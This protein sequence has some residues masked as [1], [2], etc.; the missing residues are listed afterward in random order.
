MKLPGP[1]MPIAYSP[2]TL[3]YSAGDNITLRRQGG[4]KKSKMAEAGESMFDLDGDGS[5]LIDSIL[6][7]DESK[8]VFCMLAMADELGHKSPLPGFHTSS[9][10][11]GASAHTRPRPLSLSP[12]PPGRNSE[13]DARDWTPGHDE[14]HAALS[15]QTPQL[16]EIEL[17]RRNSY[18]AKVSLLNPFGIEI[19]P[20]GK[21]EP[22]DPNTTAVIDPSAAD[23][24]TQSPPG[25]PVVVTPAVVSGDLY[26]VDGEPAWEGPLVTEGDGEDGVV[27]DGEATL[28]GDDIPTDTTRNQYPDPEAVATKMKL[29]D[30]MLN[31]LMN[32]SADVNI[33]VKEMEKSLE[34]SYKEIKD[35]KKENVALKLRL[36]NLELEDRRTQFHAKATDDKL[37]RL[38]T[39]TKKKNLILE[40]IPEQDGRREVLEKT[41][42]DVFDQLDV[43]KGV[44]FEACYRI[45]P[46]NKAKSRPILISFEK[47]VD[48]ELIYSRRMDL[49]RTR[50]YQ[51]VWVNEDLGAAS[52]RK[53]G[54]I[55]LSAKEAQA[56]GIDCRSGKYSLHIDNTRYDDDNLTELPPRLQPSNLKQVKIDDKTLVYQSEHAPFSNFYPC[57]LQV[58][59]HKF[60]CLEQ[61]F[62][63]MRAKTL[64]KHLIATKIYLSRDVRFIKQ[65]GNE[66]GTAEEWEARKFEVMYGL[67]KKKFEQHPTLRALLLAT[68][69]FELVEATPDRTWDCG[70]TLSSNVLR[71][72]EW[73]G[74]NKHGETLMTVRDELLAR[75]RV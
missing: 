41:I 26:G 12:I 51:H 52:K 53:R 56:Q 58:G 70:A 31:Q 55:R 4:L 63:F 69:G 46:Y 29:V 45:G 25:A 30:D 48:R 19:S 8:D 71:R 75:V 13:Q 3:D 7:Q 11:G 64:G 18:N 27:K 9:Q 24:L 20:H 23:P 16:G 68:A 39:A 6:S 43:R 28:L 2:A 73:P 36:D 47:Q 17:N 65:L 37:D 35:L 42:S 34:F 10:M 59:Q 33:T 61:A 62:Q 15:Y 21:Q 1:T 22:A 74:Q 67:L 57:V 38:E 14:I 50:D 40:G 72:H 32:R 66:L 49:K 54:L 60:F 44:T 5:L